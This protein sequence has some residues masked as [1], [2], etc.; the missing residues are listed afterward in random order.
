MGKTVGEGFDHIGA[1]VETIANAA[2]DAGTRSNRRAAR[3]S[4]YSSSPVSD[5][6][7]G[8]GR[9]WYSV[10]DAR[11]IMSSATTAA[12]SPGTTKPG[13]PVVSATNTIAAS[14]TR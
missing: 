6:M 11:R 7:P 2:L 13:R 3:L 1:M 14:G 10:T 12:M 9:T 4:R 8:S 5:A